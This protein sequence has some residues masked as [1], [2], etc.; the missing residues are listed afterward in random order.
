M[1]RYIY[2]IFTLLLCSAFAF[3][4]QS[5]QGKVVDASSKETLPFA[6]VVL[7]KDGVQV[8]GTTTDFDG[9]YTLT[10]FDPGT[11]NIKV[12]Y[13]GYA[14]KEVSGIT[15]AASKTVP[16][17][18]ELNVGETLTEIVVVEY[19]APLIEADN[20]A[21][22]QTLT[23][24]DVEKLPTKSVSTLV[25]TTAGLSANVREDGNFS[26]RG[27]REGD[28]IIFVDG[29]RVRGSS[30]PS[31][32]IEQLQVIT[33]G[34]PASYGDVTGGIVN[35]TTKGPSSEFSGSLE[36]ETSEFLDPFGYNFVNASIAGPLVQRKVTRA[37]GSEAKESLIGFRF[38][39]EF[40]TAKDGSP[41][42]V[43][44]WQ[45]T[46][47]YLD[48]IEADPLVLTN[49]GYVSRAS[50]ITENDF[51]LTDIK[52]N[53]RVMDWNVN[54]KLDFKLSNAIDI[55][56]GANYRGSH[57]R[58]TFESWHLLNHDRNPFTDATDLRGFFRFRHRIGQTGANLT[59][60]EA[61][62]K[63][64]SWIQNVYYTL[65]FDYTKNTRLTQDIEHEDDLFAYGY[66]G[67]FDVNRAPV[68]ATTF[69]PMTQTVTDS[70]IGFSTQQ[71]AF[72]RANTTNPDL[73]NWAEYDGIN[74]G[75]VRV[76]N[77]L[78]AG[79]F[80]DVYNVNNNLLHR[81]FGWIYN[82]YFDSENNQY[83]FQANGAFDIAKPGVENPSKHSIQ[84]GFLYEQRED[85]AYNINPFSLWQLAR[86]L[87]NADL[88]LD[89][90]NPIYSTNPDNGNTQVDFNEI[91]SE[92]STFGRELRARLGAAPGD[93]INV[94]ALTPSDLSIDLFSA[95]EL[96]SNGFNAVRI[97]YWG[98]D[99]TGAKVG[100]ESSFSD[101][102]TQRDARGDLLRPVAP[103]QPIYTAGYIQDKF[104]FKDIFF[105]IGVRVD[106]YDANQE[107]LKDP[108]LLYGA[109]TV[110][111]AGNLSHPANVGTDWIV[112]VDNIDNPQ[113]VTGYRD[114]EQWYTNQ[115]TP[116]N[117]PTTIY[118]STRPNPY[119][120]NG[121]SEDIKN[122][123]FDPSNSFTDYDPQITVMP[124][125]AFS[126][127]ISQDAG[128]FAHYDV[129]AARPSGNS[130]TTALDYYYFLDLINRGGINNPNL[131]PSKTVDYEV[132]FQQRI[133]NSSAIKV[134][135]Y[136]KELRDMVQSRQ[137]QYAY[138]S[139]AYT[140]FD[141]L[142]FGT[143]K[144]FSFQY[145][146]R[147]T[148]NVRLVANYTLQFADGTGSNTT[149]QRGISN[150]GNI[151]VIYPFDYDQRHTFNGI[152]DYR[153]G[154]GDKYNGPRIGGANIFANTGLNILLKVASGRPYTKNSKPAAFGSNEIEGSLNGARL[155]WTSQVDV[156]LDK[157]FKIGGKDG[158]KGMFLNVYLRSQNL[159]NTGNV[160]S[161]FSFTQSATDDGFLN[162]A[163]GQTIKENQIAPESFELLY[164]LRLKRNG[165]Y[166]LPR[167][168]RLGA[169]MTF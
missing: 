104:T 89:T 96:I 13:V 74:D 68:Y 75:G 90:S 128:F 69:D 132:G 99:Y 6:N 155:P 57:D 10:G 3:G 31:S 166:G 164:N 27:S 165:F 32:D 79:S 84:F 50:F 62:D 42:W 76:T 163:E 17:D 52:P 15:V 41:G 146:M 26:I 16:V 147:R 115:G 4:Q 5:I 161:V 159:L 87:A 92:N 114:G 11:F 78:V 151:R 18:I 129:L 148:G 149:S 43:G 108:F 9:N 136:Y 98:Y 58:N 20:T 12:I 67:Q 156:R 125:I 153:Y 152:I 70:L 144:G 122:D 28:N 23:S 45:A 47:S 141:N 139:F 93:W 30:V 142:D 44:Y 40:T 94:D 154:S 100:G 48:Q 59:A 64:A 101:F 14:D 56:I 120:I 8:V 167:R 51:E 169:I 140:S 77:G 157:D 111:E 91:S 145:D 103:F 36:L 86:Q 135:V 123:D 143:V 39:G 105:N 160:V 33:G 71:G 80:P 1:A 54:G 138:P 116:V 110:A 46:D 126:F 107:V 83:S 134:S 55:T 124:R 106:R 65:Q 60:D 119:L 113:S 19:T 112:Y 127:P 38:S 133:S 162:S 97:D 53:A 24:K 49:Q 29:V 7:L 102:F 131:K 118:G 85:R 37:D 22:G 66:I 121:S 150:R 95:N 130:L 25:S 21:G 158:K 2:L 61:K 81:N 168:V 88:T 73:A 63:T 109:R 117:S 35:I 72:S 137:F 34:L 82:G